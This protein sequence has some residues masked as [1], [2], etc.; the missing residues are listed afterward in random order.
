MPQKS[1]TRAVLGLVIYGRG[2]PKPG[3]L[4][5]LPVM[6]LIEQKDLEKTFGWLDGVSVII[7]I[8]IGSGIFASPGPVLELTKSVLDIH[9]LGQHY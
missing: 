1:E 2:S 5:T 8:T 6:S 3:C 4:K 9:R 7:G